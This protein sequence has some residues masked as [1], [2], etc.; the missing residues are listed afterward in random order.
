[1][2]FKHLDIEGIQL[3]CEVRRVR[4]KKWHERPYFEVRRML[5]GSLLLACD[6]KAEADATAVAVAAGLFEEYTT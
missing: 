3:R 5:D 2:K 1:M 4:P 6:D